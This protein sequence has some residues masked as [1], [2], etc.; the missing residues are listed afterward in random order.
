M[1]LF[2]LTANIKKLFTLWCLHLLKY[3]SN[4]LYIEFLGDK[5]EVQKIISKLRPLIIS[6]DAYSEFYI[7]VHHSVRGSDNVVQI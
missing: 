6:I 3:K 4:F 5:V 7:V 1:S 2:I